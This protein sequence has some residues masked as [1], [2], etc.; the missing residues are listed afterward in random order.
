MALWT[1]THWTSFIIDQTQKITSCSSDNSLYVHGGMAGE[2]FYDDMYRLDLSESQFLM[3]HQLNTKLSGKKYTFGPKAIISSPTGTNEWSKIHITTVQPSPRAAH[4]SALHNGRVYM[5]GG[6]SKEGALD[7]LWV[8]DCS[9][10]IV[11][12]EKRSNCFVSEIS[13]RW[14]LPT[15]QVRSQIYTSFQNFL[16]LTNLSLSESIEWNEVKVAPPSP[17]PRLDHC[18]CVVTVP[19]CRQNIGKIPDWFRSSE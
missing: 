1:Q 2:V 4:I 8:F 3:W 18:M 10:C 9:K 19:Y 7:D 12:R 15:S 5:F 6:L 17:H 11:E 16:K 13:R 14:F